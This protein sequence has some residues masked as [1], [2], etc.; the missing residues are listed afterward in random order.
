M[1]LLRSLIF[2]LCLLAAL[3]AAA[4][5]VN[6][7][8]GVAV[9]GTDVVAYFRAGRAVPGR[10]EFVHVWN[11]ATWRFSSAEN[12]DAFA[13]EPARFAPQYGGFCAWA[14]SQGYRAPIDPDAW[15]IVDGRLFLNYSRAI[16]M[17][18]DLMR[19]SNIAAGD[20]NW[21]KLASERP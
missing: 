21:P 14:V 2:A 5:T 9:Q 4:Q 1:T 11:G 20:K 13:A 18:W 6:A 19:A 7:E 3:P 17:R 15:R 8:N 10:A 16:Q 12:R